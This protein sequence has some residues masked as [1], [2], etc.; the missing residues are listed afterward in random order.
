[1]FTFFSF[2]VILYL[3]SLD[4]TNLRGNG[5]MLFTLNR[6]STEPLYMQIKR[7]LR[8]MIE[9]GT[10]PPGYCLP[11]ERKLAESLGVNRTTILNAF[12]DLKAEGFLSSHVGQGT[13]VCHPAETEEPE[14]SNPLPL[15][16][17]H[18]FSTN[19]GCYDSNAYRPSGRP[20]GRF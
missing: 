20:A 10:L 14:E 3:T 9:N 5:F 8:E 19:S 13:V 2:P 7:R 11:P 15:A 18:L 4:D 12:R 17:R 1:M 6:D 16:W